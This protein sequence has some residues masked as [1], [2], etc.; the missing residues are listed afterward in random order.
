MM[1]L[2]SRALS[3]SAKFTPV[4]TGRVTAPDRLVMAPIIRSRSD[5]QDAPGDIAATYDAQL[6]LT[7]WTHDRIDWKIRGHHMDTVSD[8]KTLRRGQT[9]AEKNHIYLNY[10]AIMAPNKPTP[11]FPSCGLSLAKTAELFNKNNTLHV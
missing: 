9:P 8:E 2:R 11:I 6:W 4:R 7:S 5:D 1:S 3:T 10:T